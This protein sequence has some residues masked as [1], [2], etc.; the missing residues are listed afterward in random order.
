MKSEKVKILVLTNEDF[1][2][3]RVDSN[4]RSRRQQI[5][6]LPPLATR[7]HSQILSWRSF[8]REVYSNINLLLCQVFLLKTQNIFLKR[9]DFKPLLW[10]NTLKSIFPP[11][12]Q[13]DNAAD[14]DS[15]ERGFESLRAGQ[16]IRLVSTSRIFLSIAKQVVFH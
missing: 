9:V 2:W 7:E 3:E 14:S 10:Y 1:W 6:S 11:V 8:N 5:Y 16:K 15:E 4:H 12:A 13:L